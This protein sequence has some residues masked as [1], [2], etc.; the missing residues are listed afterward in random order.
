MHV[1]DLLI[2]PRSI[3]YWRNSVMGVTETSMCNSCCMAFWFSSFMYRI[4]QC[5]K[6]NTGQFIFVPFCL[7]FILYRPVWFNFHEGWR[8]LFAGFIFYRMM[9]D[10]DFRFSILPRTHM[11]WKGCKDYNKKRIRNRFRKINYELSLKT[12]YKM[13]ASIMLLLPAHDQRRRHFP[14]K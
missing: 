5:Q 1:S 14:W 8:F 7:S 9:L 6:P 12:C 4:R 11:C 2:D 10:F 3:T 13:T